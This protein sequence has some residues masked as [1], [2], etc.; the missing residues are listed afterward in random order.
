[1]CRVLTSQLVLGLAL[2]FGLSCPG[3]SGE[4][5]SVREARR[6]LSLEQNQPAIDVL[7]GD[8]SGEA[9]YLRAI[10]LFRLQLKDAGL[11]QAQAA[12]DAKPDEP[13]YQAYLMRMKLLL[14]PEASEKQAA[15]LIKFTEAHPSKA[16]F[17]LFSTGAYVLRQDLNRARTGF[18]TAVS[19]ADQIPEFWPELLNLAMDVGDFKTAESIIQKIDKVSPNE[20]FIQKQRVLLLAATGDADQ[21]TSLAKSLYEEGEQSGDLAM[22]YAQALIN[23]TPGPEL[24]EK[25]T[26]LV[27]RHPSQA[28]LLIL[29]ATYLGKSNRLNV[30]LDQLNKV[31]DT[32]PLEL[33][34]ALAPVLCM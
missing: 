33:K 24:D 20:P 8:K 34:K 11:E 5:K 3:C 2:L 9:C 27:N 31:M 7:G 19:L 25:L 26:E 29:Y 16:A 28:G 12:V 1:M 15:E 4:S 22:L 23:G 18:Q 30:A 14:N 6:Y 21:A 13:K 10:G 17:A 32:Q